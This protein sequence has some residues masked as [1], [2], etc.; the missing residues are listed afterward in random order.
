MNLYDEVLKEVFWFGK[1]PVS[2]I[3]TVKSETTRNEFYEKF[4]KIVKIDDINRISFVE[5]FKR[6]NIMRKMAKEVYELWN[7]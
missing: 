3:S 1:C 4:E 5:K 2:I 7:Y 6:E